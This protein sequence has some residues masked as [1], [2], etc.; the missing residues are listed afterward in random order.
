MK[1]FWCAM[2]AMLVIA[3]VSG[4][5]LEQI[6]LPSDEMNTAANVRLD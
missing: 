1:A 3:L 2:L 4:L 5:V 6:G